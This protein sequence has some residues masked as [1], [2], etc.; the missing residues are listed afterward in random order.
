MPVEQDGRVVALVAVGV[1]TDAIGEEV[2]AL[3]PG[4]L[5]LAAIVL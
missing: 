1:L 3:L 5:G 4:L 2:A